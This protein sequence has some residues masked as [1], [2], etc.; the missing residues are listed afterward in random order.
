M[1]Q[2]SITTLLKPL[3][4][5]LE[6]QKRLFWGN[7]LGSF[8]LIVL[9]SGSQWK[10]HIK[11]F[12]SPRIWWHPSSRA[13]MKIVAINAFVR[14]LFLSGSLAG[15]TA[16]AALLSLALT[17]IVGA[18]PDLSLATGKVMFFYAL[19]IFLADDYARYYL[20]RLQHSCSWLWVF[21]ETHHSALVLTPL[22]LMR[23]HPIEIICSQIRDVIT[24]GSVGGLFFYLFGPSLDYGDLLGMQIFG[25]LFN[26]LGANLRHSHVF[27]HFGPLEGIVI[28]PAAHQIHHSQ[29]PAHYD[30]NFGVCLALWDRLGGSFFDPRQV[31][32]PLV[33]GLDQSPLSR[34]EQPLLPLYTHAFRQLFS[35]FRNAIPQGH[36]A[37]LDTKEHGK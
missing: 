35:R 16:L 2:I 12:L 31:Q 33:F 25:L 4:V 8:F 1:D 13:D 21:H 20:H 14:T 5:L 23:T 11:T 29:D 26:F 32:K 9:L 30:K 19:V 3:S 17:K 36:L 37:T 24:Y 7:L 27:L 28:S 10:A 6:P 18:K 34:P 15:S 22:T